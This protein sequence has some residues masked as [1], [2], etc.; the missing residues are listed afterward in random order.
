M[1]KRNK[2]FLKKKIIFNKDEEKFHNLNLKFNELQNNFFKHK[3]YLKEFVF[4]NNKL[5]LDNK[6]LCK[7]IIDSKNNKKD[8]S[9]KIFNII[10]FFLENKNEN[11]EKQKL[12]DFFKNQ[13]SDFFSENENF[14]KVLSEKN[15]F[16]LKNKDFNKKEGIFKN[17]NF[18][19]NEFFFKNNDNTINDSFLKNKDFVKNDFLLKKNNFSKN[20]SLLKNKKSD[21]FFENK[22]N[23]NLSQNNFFLEKLEKKTK[24][25]NLENLLTKFVKDSQSVSV[26]SRKSSDE[27][28]FFEKKKKN[29]SFFYIN[30]MNKK[31]HDSKTHDSSLSFHKN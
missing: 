24:E 29:N 15:S 12:D 10:K 7:E 17:N 5:I 28:L 31:N 8:N 3:E 13:N 2:K 14:Q 19:D 25:G 9:K 23:D 21:F 1:I 22:K 6:F 27:N 18:V 16:F 4:Q 11:K 26:I 20:D 30:E